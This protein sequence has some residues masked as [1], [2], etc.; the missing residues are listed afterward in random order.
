M[1]H[2]CRNVLQHHDIVH[3]YVR[4]EIYMPMRKHANT[5]VMPRHEEKF[6]LNLIT[7]PHQQPYYKKSREKKKQ[8]DITPTIYHLLVKTQLPVNYLSSNHSGLGT[9]TTAL[10][11]LVHC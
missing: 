4:I 7:S 10:F 1:M 8:T 9:H 11:Q 3:K 6:K 2:G 5:N